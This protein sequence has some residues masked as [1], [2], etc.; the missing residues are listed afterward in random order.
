MEIVIQTLTSSL[1]ALSLE[2]KVNLPGAKVVALLGSIDSITGFQH[3]ADLTRVQT[4]REIHEKLESGEFQG[5]LMDAYFLSHYKINY[6]TSNLRVQEVIQHKHLEYGVRVK[7]IK[8][9]DC[10]REKRYTQ[11]ADLY[12]HAE[13]YLQQSLS[14]NFENEDDNQVNFFD[15][16]GLLYFPVFYVCFG[17]TAFLMMAGGAWDLYH[18]VNC[19]FIK[20]GQRS[21]KD[22]SLL[23]SRKTC[24]ISQEKLQDLENKIQD[25]SQTFDVIKNGIISANGRYSKGFAG[26][27]TE[28]PGNHV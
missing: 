20:T 27:S 22:L 19:L 23:L 8:L 18:N 7:D 24:D 26:A 3:Q 12:E 10:F 16:K 13:I 25:L 14:S 11:E 4:P 9:A 2:T 6:P 28:R 5:A 15:P 17:V 1:T 21:R